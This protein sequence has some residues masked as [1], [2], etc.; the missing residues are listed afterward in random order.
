M[1]L[2]LPYMPEV[3]RKDT[4]RLW[5][6][7][8][9]ILILGITHLFVY[10]IVISDTNYTDQLI[11]MLEPSDTILKPEI[12]ESLKKRPLLSITPAKSDWDFKRL[13]FANFI[14]GSF[15]HLF[16]NLIGVF[17]GVRICSSF[18][19]F[20]W[21]FIIFSVGGSCGL[22]SSIVFST[23]TLDYIPH[24]GAS[25]GIFALMGT[26]YIFNFRYRTRYFFWFPTKH[27]TIALKTSWFFFVDVIVL[28]LIL[29]ISQFFPTRVDTIDHIAHVI[30]FIS[31]L[32]IA[33]SFKT[34]IKWPSFIQTKSEYNVWKKIKPLDDDGYLSKCVELLSINYYNDSVKKMLLE[35][36]SKNIEKYN[37]DDIETIFSFI[38]PTF[39]RLYSQASSQAIRTVLKNNKPLPSI[40]LKSLP[41]DSFI[42]IAKK[43]TLFPNEQKI[44]MNFIYNFCE[45]H[46][47]ESRL[48]G[49]I[50]FFK[51]RIMD[52]IE[53]EKITLNNKLESK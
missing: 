44:L 23:E 29:S 28:E 4:P 13:F 16:L 19:S 41:Y 49:K 33:F 27:G 15:S 38:S 9:F 35:H 7:L 22:F 47:E 48:A 14:H 34:L 30:G 51:S 31:G 39:I 5:Q 32:I 8:I 17:A 36:L 37:K 6:G 45:V 11:L 20:F 43:L 46:P 50:E 26:Y 3:P 25:A 53:E 18:I 21:I 2:L 24:V 40:W 10:D 1:I 12:I 42:R 52:L